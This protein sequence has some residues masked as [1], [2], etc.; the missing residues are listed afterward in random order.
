MKQTL[1]V[2]ATTPKQVL[3]FRIHLRA[4]MVLMPLAWIVWLLTPATYPWPIWSTAAWTVGIIFHYLGVF[5]F[6][7]SNLKKSA[8]LS[9]LLVVAG[10]G[11][12]F[13]TEPENVNEQVISSFKKDFSTAQDVSWE[14]TQEISKATFTLN[15]QVMFAWYAENGKQVAVIRNILSSQ[16][17]INLLTSLKNNY[18]GYWI[19]DLFEMVADNT[20]TYYIT[21]EDSA[22]KIVLKS[23]DYTTWQTFK[24]EDKE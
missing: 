8:L 14:K 10:I 3:G 1:S 13:A 22:H 19:S 17:P 7:K 12:S 5:V 21:I 20:T 6:K 18:A 11:N 15:G 24:K 2:Y 23:E 4:F 16:L 9:I